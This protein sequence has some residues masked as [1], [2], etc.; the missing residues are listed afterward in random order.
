MVLHAVVMWGLYTSGLTHPN[1][2]RGRAVLNDQFPSSAR[3]LVLAGLF[4]G[5]LSACGGG[6]DSAPATASPSP[7]PAPAS[8]TRWISS[9]A[10]VDLAGGADSGIDGPLLAIDPAHPGT[11][12]PL[13][14]A[15]V[16]STSVRIMGGKLDATL[17]TLDN[18]APRF[19]VYDAPV[20]VGTE[21][22]FA[23]YKLALDAT[24][25][26]APAPQRLST[27][28]TMCP[29]IGT[30]FKVV[31][32]SL[33]GDEALITFAAP[34]SAG[35][36]TSGGEPKLVKLGMSS[37]S[38]PLALPVATA[39]RINPIGVIHGSAGQMAAVLAWQNGHFVRTDASLANP[40]A[41]AAT[42]VAGVIDANATP[43]APGIVTRYGIF[44]KSADGLRRY[45]K[46][47]GKISAVLLTGQVGQGAQINEM[48]D[49]QA[50]YITR[51]SAGGSLDL[52]RVDDTATPSVV[53]INN[54]NTEGALDP[55][56]FRVMKSAVLYAVAGRNDFNVWRKSDGARSNVLDGKVVVLSSSLSDRVFHNTTDTA[57]NTT[58][59]SSLYDGSDARSLGAARVLSGA[60]AAQTTPFARTLRGNG[61]FAHA[62]VLVPTTGQSSLAGAAVRWLSFDSA[63]SDVDAGSL[64]T[65]LA[66]GLTPQAPGIISDAGLFAV[67]KAGT[68][69]AYVFVSQ[70]AAGS[71][72]RIANG[73]Q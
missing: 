60:L 56:G 9:A 11:S 42:D 13:S 10:Q 8:S 36:C 71:L 31:G 58:L 69:E 15:T 23:L 62:V 47:S 64:P 53:Q 4:T 17:S 25:S 37:S 28:I 65:N 45:D 66:M 57:G 22:S 40:V 26:A 35:S 46:S 12:A 67:P 14:P 19:V 16:D 68:S 20:T 18:P 63:A 51:A 61:A 2:F 52:F 72:A 30:R 43:I 1:D 32:Q 54:T 44:I 5:V 55:W 48:T 50:L 49:G 39:D 7:T 70:R 73:V 3:R 41:L 29:A 6:G 38:A 34:D 27:Q 21:N 59:A 33:A 24:G